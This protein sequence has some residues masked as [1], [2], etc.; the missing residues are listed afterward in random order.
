MGIRR[1]IRIRGPIA[2]VAFAFENTNID[3]R[4]VNL[5]PIG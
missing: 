3:V 4:R 1:P 2:D 5:G